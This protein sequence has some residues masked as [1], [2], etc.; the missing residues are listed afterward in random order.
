MSTA[1][2]KK[3]KTG[4]GNVLV[5]DVGNTNI[6]FGVFQGDYILASFRMVSGELRT[7]DEYGVLL[8][9]MLAENNVDYRNIK[10][11][12]MASVVPKLVHSMTNAIIK[13][14]NCVPFVVGP[15]IKS[16]ISIKS[17]N[18]KEI[19]PDLI[20]DCAASY[21]IYGGPVLSIDFGTAT[22]YILVNEKGELIAGAIAP[23]IRISAKALWEDTAKLPEIEIKKPDTIMGRD[24][25]STMQ[26]GLIYGQIG[27]S[28]YIINEFKRQSGM[29]DMKV[30]A[31]GGLGRLISDEVSEIDVYDPLLTLKGLRIIYEKNR[32]KHPTAKLTE[33]E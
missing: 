32:R 33:T 8:R 25:V 23:G 11:V 20:V 15:G 2:Q 28:K 13:Y 1:V 29:A 17:E 16:G 9:Q 18:P 6:T 26:A 5:I 31:T 19:G 12:I 30:V 4:P 24:T 22:T 21:E 27:Q 7:S 3:E 10:G 14:I